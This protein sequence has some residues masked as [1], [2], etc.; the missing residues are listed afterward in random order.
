MILDLRSDSNE[1]AFREED[2]RPR[3]W[4]QGG[5]WGELKEGHSKESGKSESNQKEGPDNKVLEDSTEDCGFFFC[6][7]GKNAEIRRSTFGK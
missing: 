6:E 4:S 5:N 1:G 3:K 2:S 7:Q